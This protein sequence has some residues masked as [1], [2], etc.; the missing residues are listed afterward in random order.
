ME[1]NVI[2]KHARTAAL[3]CCEGSVYEMEEP[4]RISLNGVFYKESRQVVNLLQ[5]LEPGKEY[6]VSVE[7]GKEAAEIMFCTDTQ[8]YTLNVRDF[9]AK[10]D[11][12][13]DD[14]TYIQAAIM[15][16]PRNSR[17]LIPEGTYRVTSLFLKDHLTME[18][19]K[20]AVL[21]AYTERERFSIL[22][23]TYQS[24][25]QEN[26][27]ILGT[28]EGEAQ[29]MFA[30]IMNGIGIKDVTICG[31]GT[32]D[33]NASWENWWLDAKEVRGAARPRMIFLNRCE[34]VTITG[35]TVQN[36]PSW[37][38]HPYFCSHLKFIGVTV[39]GPK[40]SP[41]TDGLNPE[42]CDD[43]EITGCLFSVGD[44][45]IAVKAGKIS[46][47]AKY[48]VPS[49]NI[50]IRQC[51]MRDGHGSIT[52]G[53]EMAAGI[54][55]LQARQCVFLN[56]DRGL[57]IKTRRGRGKDAVIDGILFE[58]IRMDSV[59]TPFVINSFYFCDPDGHSEY[60]QCKEP[61]AVDE[62][63]P[64]IKELCFRNIQA[65]NCHVAAA[66][67]YGLPEQKIERVEMKH[68]QVSYAED[69]ASGQPAMMDGI[70][71]NICKMGIFARNI[72]TLVLEDIQVVGQ[73]GEV[74]SMDGIDS[75]EWR[76]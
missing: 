60:V 35:I 75:L 66:F 43:V 34:D 5:G 69:A 70:D 73:E 4:C 64:Q 9:G 53:S 42:S 12:V 38:I 52:L 26:E 54:K 76:K 49:S 46:V 29:N 45:C 59:L 13:Q 28:W 11:G 39:L 15:S 37:N 58:D 55:N 51:C 30:G 48:K 25:D 23:G 33:G 27:Y 67:F 61:L 74:I 56:T 10:G 31:E 44:D 17:V 47:G 71:Q 72:K 40:V 32:I 6:H 65:K 68:I 24:E 22:R 63:T 36:S 50:R 14:T 1:L 8:D 3:E 19:A 2:W 7:R 62:R 21:S 18:L 41:N 57:R 20:G 16:C